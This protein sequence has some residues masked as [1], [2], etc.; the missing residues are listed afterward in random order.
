M[1]TKPILMSAM[2]ACALLTAPALSLAANHTAQANQVVK[3]QKNAD[4]ATY[5]GVIKGYQVQ[6]YT[7]RASKGQV[8]NA[9]V[10]GS[11]LAD[12]VLYG[13]D[14]FQAGEDYT[15]PQTGEY[16]LIVVQPRAFARRNAVSPYTL[17]IGIRNTPQQQSHAQQPESV[18][19]TPV[20]ENTAARAKNE[21][22]VQ[23]EVRFAAGKSSAIYRG[24][25]KGHGYDQYRF[26]ARAGQMLRVK[27]INGRS[28]ASLYG[29]DDF[30]EGVPYV[31]PS[32]GTYEVRVTQPRALARK[33]TSSKYAVKIQI[34]NRE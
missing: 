33:N 22:G 11:N 19:A 31:L 12:V 20:A 4:S 9:K 17:T 10:T 3:F 18:V 26:Q 14:G 15:L 32:T 8:L 21:N 23:R 16:K 6:T 7:F 1:K 24:R 29:F 28:A 27:V 5:R 30:V 13:F 25:L 34:E 2:A